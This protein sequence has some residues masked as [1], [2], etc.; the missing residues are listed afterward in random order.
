MFNLWHS[1]YSLAKSKIQS[2]FVLAGAVTVKLPAHRRYT[3]KTTTF[4]HVG[5]SSGT[6]VHIRYINMLWIS[7]TANIR[8]SIR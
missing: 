3:L 8:Q 7:I 6:G 2:A 5:A 4:E 1:T